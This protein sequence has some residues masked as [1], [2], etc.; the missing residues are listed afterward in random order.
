MSS[1]PPIDPDIHARL[2]SRRESPGRGR[3]VFEHVLTQLGV[4]SDVAACGP[5]QEL[6]SGALKQTGIE[7]TVREY[8]D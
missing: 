6:A 2:D 5:K 1:T 3:R 8:L 4:F 7:C